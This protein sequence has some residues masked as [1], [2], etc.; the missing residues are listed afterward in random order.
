MK[1]IP[2]FVMLSHAD[3]HLY[4]LHA[5]SGAVNRQKF[6]VDKLPALRYY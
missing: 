5:S 6:E 4:I 2:T 1:E 3:T